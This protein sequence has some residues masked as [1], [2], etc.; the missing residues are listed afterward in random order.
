MRLTLPH[1]V[2]LAAACGPGADKVEAAAVLHAAN[3][4]RDAPSEPASARLGHLESLERAPATTPHAARARDACAHAYRL[5][6]EGNALEAKVRAAIATPSGLTP[7]ILRDLGTAE[8]K[9]KESTTAMPTCD[10]A[11]ADLRRWLR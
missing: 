6:L 7:D 11:L 9:I 10:E 5:L 3:V 4:L 8:D 2:L 1:V